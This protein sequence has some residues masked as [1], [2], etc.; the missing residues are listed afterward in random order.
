MYASFYLRIV[1]MIFYYNDIICQ[2]GY[3]WIP[4]P[5]VRLYL[6]IVNMIIYYADILSSW[7]RMDSAVVGGAKS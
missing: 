2:A 3:G 6:R 7:S 1:N 4:Q 5:Q